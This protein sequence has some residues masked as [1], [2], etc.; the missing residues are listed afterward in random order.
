[1]NK[2]N[3]KLVLASLFT[4]TGAFLKLFLG[5]SIILAIVGQTLCAIAQPIIISSPGKIATTWFRE[6][7]VFIK[8]SF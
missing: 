3:L 5:N 7:R 1:M 8:I 4:S 6:E 2:I